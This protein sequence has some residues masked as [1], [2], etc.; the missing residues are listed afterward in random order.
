MK[1]L[2]FTIKIIDLPEKKNDKIIILSM[3]RKDI[4]QL[5]H[6]ILKNRIQHILILFMTKNNPDNVNNEVQIQLQIMINGKLKVKSTFQLVRQP[7]S[8]NGCFPK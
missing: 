5:G 3:H 1:G 8:Y 6:L 2:K 4:E 7:T